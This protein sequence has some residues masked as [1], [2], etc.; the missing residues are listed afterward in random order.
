MKIKNIGLIL[1]SYEKN[2]N[3]TVV[4]LGNILSKGVRTAPNPHL[5][6]LFFL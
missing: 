5:K 3:N 2:I 6:Q 4:F 1:W